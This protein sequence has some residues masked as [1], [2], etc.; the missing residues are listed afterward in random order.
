MEGIGMEKGF[1]LKI[2]LIIGLILYKT[3]QIKNLIQ[4]REAIYDLSTYITTNTTN[5]LITDQFPCSHNYTVVCMDLIHAFN[6]FQ[7]L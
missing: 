2:N 5:E 6:L 7:L 1:L 3:Q 4:Y